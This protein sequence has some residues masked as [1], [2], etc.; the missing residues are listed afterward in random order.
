MIEQPLPGATFFLDAAAARGLDYNFAILL[1]Y[2]AGPRGSRPLFAHLMTMIF[3]SPD[4][5]HCYA[6]T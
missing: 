6:G 2:R 3:T 5:T 4:G 1:N